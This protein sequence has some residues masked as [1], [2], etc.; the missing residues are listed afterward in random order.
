MLAAN[1]HTRTAAYWPSDSKVI[2]NFSLDKAF[3]T[4]G[5]RKNHKGVQ[6]PPKVIFNVT[7]GPLRTA[8]KVIF[9]VTERPPLRTPEIISNATGRVSRGFE[10]FQGS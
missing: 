2:I 8:P 3:R 10:G 9:D 4:L 6:T 5:P 1:V 7:G